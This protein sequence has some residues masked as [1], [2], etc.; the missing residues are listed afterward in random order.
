MRGGWL[1][2]WALSVLTALSLA[3]AQPGA[4]LGSEFVARYSAAE[5]TEAAARLYPRGTARSAQ[6]S[7]DGYFLRFESRDEGGQSVE[8]FAQLYL[9]VMTETTFLPIFGVGV[10]TT[11]LSDDCAPSLERPGVSNWGDYSAQALAYAGQGFITILPDPIG[12]G[13]PDRIARYFV[14]QA[15][16]QMLLDAARAV[17][18]FFEEAELALRP[19]EAV[20]FGGYSHGGNMVFAASD[21]AADYAP[22]LEL[23][24]VIGYG[25]TT[26]V[27]AMLRANPYFAPYLVHAYREIY[28]AERADPAALLQ[29]GVAATLEEDVMSR[30]VDVIFSFYG[31]DPAGVFSA[32][33]LAA[34]EAGDFGGDFAPFGEL[35]AENSAGLAGSA[36]PALVLQGTADT[37]VTRGQQ[38]SFVRRACEAGTPVTY[39]TYSNVEHFQTRQFGFRDSLA[40]MR[41]LIAEGVPRNDCS[42]LAD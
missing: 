32:D 3:H 2:L 16:G 4:V 5:V 26:D 23:L 14:A 13:D 1:R 20:F 7:V 27:A 38:E 22:E 15:S 31:S 21:L 37:I 30:C 36:V 11:G 6:Y 17:Y 40:W 29:G 19:A 41:S 28:G 42:R 8:V 24:G 35:L 25:P 9:P 12:F 10:G 34:L 18:G 33:F 39:V